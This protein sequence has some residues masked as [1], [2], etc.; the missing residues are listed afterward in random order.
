MLETRIRELVESGQVTFKGAVRRKYM[1][2][3][4]YGPVAM[5]GIQWADE[6]GE[7]RAASI[8]KACAAYWR[9]FDEKA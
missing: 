1:A 4:A 3:G 5:V 8:T 2:P 6:N 7:P 9:I